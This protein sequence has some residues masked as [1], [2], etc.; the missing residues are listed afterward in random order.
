MG[1]HR[2]KAHIPWVPVP[3]ADVKP[4]KYLGRYN[5][6]LQTGALS[7]QGFLVFFAGGCKTLQGRRWGCCLHS[8]TPAC[9]C[10]ENEACEPAVFFCR[11]R[12]LTTS[13]LIVNSG[14]QSQLPFIFLRALVLAAVGNKTTCAQVSDRKWAWN[15]FALNRNYNDLPFPDAW[16]RLTHFDSGIW[17]VPER[18]HR[19]LHRIWH[20]SGNDAAF[21]FVACL[22]CVSL[23]HWCSAQILAVVWAAEMSPWLCPCWSGEVFTVFSRQ[24]V[25]AGCWLW[26]ISG[27][28]VVP[29]VCRH[30][31]LLL[32]RCLAFPAGAW[33]LR[34]NTYKTDMI[35]HGSEPSAQWKASTGFWLSEGTEFQSL[36]YQHF[37]FSLLWARNPSRAGLQSFMFSDKCRSDTSLSTQKPS[38]I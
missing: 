11:C 1:P 26:H 5:C 16:A 24:A 22:L 17:V 32:W 13:H 15:C 30:P 3:T 25:C 33:C 9:T 7:V 35:W 18:L 4:L 12:H 8:N 38:L 27:A 36:W 23:W 10:T 34:M 2:R 31:N 29:A 19:W 37:I 21:L 28:A 14:E 20:S 6:K